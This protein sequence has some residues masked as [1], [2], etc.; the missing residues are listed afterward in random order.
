MIF[1]L[2][3]E[4]ST[5][6]TCTNV[7][8]IVQKWMPVVSN[9]DMLHANSRQAPRPLRESF[10]FKQSFFYC[11]IVMDQAWISSTVTRDESGNLNC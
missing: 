8:L 4:V 2:M 6:F 11:V 1:N 7:F 3:N 9:L 10:Y 5:F